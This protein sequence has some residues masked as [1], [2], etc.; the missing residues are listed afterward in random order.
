MYLIYNLLFVAALASAAPEYRHDVLS[1]SGQNDFLDQTSLKLPPNIESIVAGFGILAPTE[2]PA[3]SFG[4]TAN[5]PSP[6]EASQDIANGNVAS[7]FRYQEPGEYPNNIRVS[8]PSTIILPALIDTSK[9]VE[10][11]D[12]CLP[13]QN[14]FQNQK[15]PPGISCHLAE[16]VLDCKRCNEKRQCASVSFNCPWSD[17][18]TPV[19]Y[20]DLPG[21]YKRCQLCV[22][23]WTSK[24][25]CTAP[26]SR[27]PYHIF[28]GDDLYLHPP[29]PSS[30]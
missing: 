18:E 17:D 9:C 5:Q 13:N 26:L 14:P 23:F 22:D 11:K 20:M 27:T 1:L 8:P 24:K 21:E 3:S 7:S 4:E 6:Q 29:K 16:E 2:S 10:L 12:E 28:S 25:R 30:S 15:K 19:S